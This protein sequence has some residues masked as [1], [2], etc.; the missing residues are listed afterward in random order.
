M[1]NEKHKTP[2]DKLITVYAIDKL[3]E[4]EKAYSIYRTTVNGKTVSDI[5]LV[6]ERLTEWMSILDADLIIPFEHAKQRK[7]P[8]GHRIWYLSQTN[9][10]TPYYYGCY[11]DLKI[12]ESTKRMR[13][14][15]CRLSKSAIQLFKKHPEISGNLTLNPIK[16][17]S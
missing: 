16:E 13:R 6:F 3:K 8:L 14:K 17:V 11:F 10:L 15:Q 4:L 1:L 2:V 12:V 5:S 7:E 9:R